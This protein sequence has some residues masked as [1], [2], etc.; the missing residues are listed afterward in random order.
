M[1]H[2]KGEAH[3]RPDPTNLAYDVYLATFSHP[4]LDPKDPQW[5]E[6]LQLWLEYNIYFP[7]M[8]RHLLQ[9]VV[10]GK[11]YTH[12]FQSN[13]SN[14]PDYQKYVFAITNRLVDANS[15]DWDKFVCHPL[16][17]PLEDPVVVLHY[18]FEDKTYGL[19]QIFDANASLFTSRDNGKQQKTY[20]PLKGI[21]DLEELRTSFMETLNTTP[22]K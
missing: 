2:Y 15:R 16:L 14:R 8:I 13:E 20:L 10:Q 5:V 7:P 12:V 19:L 4:D 17:V 22:K 9:L 3:E 18:F 21:P 11:D 6:I 1:K